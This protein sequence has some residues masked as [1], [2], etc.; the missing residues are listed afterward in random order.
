M[1]PYKI[2]LFF[3]GKG[4]IKIDVRHLDPTCDPSNK[5]CPRSGAIPEID[6]VFP[7]GQ[8]D[9]LVLERHFASPEARMAG[10][11]HCNFFGHLK[12]DASAC[13]AVTGILCN[14][15]RFSFLARK[16]KK[17]WTSLDK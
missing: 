13:V 1:I 17:L 3:F 11:K 12:N 4:L 2:K 10:E 5:H 8:M 9:S 16:Q 6:I 14:L 15:L 7:D